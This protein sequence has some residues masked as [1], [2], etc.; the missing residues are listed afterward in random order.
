MSIRE[1]I[2]DGSILLVLMTLVQ[3]APIKVNPWSAIWRC[4]SKS[5]SMVGTA[6]G[7][8]SESRISSRI[9][10]QRHRNG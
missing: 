9:C 6:T 4:I 2:M 5:L 7:I 1:I 10:K 3:I 8:S